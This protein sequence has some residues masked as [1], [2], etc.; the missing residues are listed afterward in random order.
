LVRGNNLEEEKLN[1]FKEEALINE[2]HFKKGSIKGTI[3]SQKAS[4]SFGPTTSADHHGENSTKKSSIFPFMPVKKNAASFSIAPISL[5]T[6]NQ[7]I[8]I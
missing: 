1:L 3:V 5:D 2:N 4:S 7:S 8:L 6:S